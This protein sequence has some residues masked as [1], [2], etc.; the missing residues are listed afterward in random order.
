MPGVGYSQMQAM[1]PAPAWRFWVTF[2]DIPG[3]PNASR[4]LPFLVQRIS[5][6]QKAIEIEPIVF[7]GGVRHFPTGWSV[8]NLTIVFAEDIKYTVVRAF[9][10]WIDTIISDTGEF[11]IPG[12]QK[13]YKKNVT[14]E[15]LDETGATVQTFTWT[16]CSP[17]RLDGYDWDGTQTMHVTPSLTMAVDGLTLQNANSQNLGA[18]NGVSGANGTSAPS[19]TANNLGVANPSGN[20][21][22]S[23]L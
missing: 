22:V 2:P 17:Q 8:D 9:R 23:Y 5:G 7:E 10:S 12:G 15:A 16:D 3:N 13:G 1:T 21:G 4:D 18:A 14:L 20:F 6:A 19:G 11:G